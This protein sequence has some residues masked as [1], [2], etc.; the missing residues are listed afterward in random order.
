MADCEGAW[1]PTGLSFFTM[2]MCAILCVPTVSGNALVIVTVI[3]NKKKKFRSPFIILVANLSLADLIVGALVEPVTVYTAAREGLN[4]DI[5][6]LPIVQYSYFLSCTASVLSLSFLTTERYLAISAPFWYRS[7]ANASKAVL[8]SGLTWVTAICCSAIFFKVGFVSYAFV[9]AHTAVT[10]TLF[11]FVFTSI[12]T[13]QKVK[14]QLME[15]TA[16]LQGNIARMATITREKK[17]IQTLLILILLFLIGYAPSLVMI[18][19]MRF[20]SLCSCELIHWMRDLHFI[21]VIGNSS[22][23]PFIYALKMPLFKEKFLKLLCCKSGET[24]NSQAAG[25][26]FHTT[27]GPSCS[28]TSHA[29][30]FRLS[31]RLETE[32]T[33]PSHALK[34]N[35]MVYLQVKQNRQRST[36]FVSKQTAWSLSFTENTAW[37]WFLENLMHS[38]KLSCKKKNF[39]LNLTFKYGHINKLIRP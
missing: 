23:N 4:L 16:D 39:P 10:F 22:V 18:Y 27:S 26:Y 1:A 12:R 33:A 29:V 2:A 11:T 6:T 31:S 24:V 36:S 34:N 9:F 35:K 38:A 15:L 28:S 13:V 14:R 20:C 25:A 3:R 17:L 19:I 21:M 37:L 30:R 32:N 7:H 8:T 5:P